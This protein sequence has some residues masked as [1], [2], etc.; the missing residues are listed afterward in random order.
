MFPFFSNTARNLPRNE[1]LIVGILVEMGAIS[2]GV[3]LKTSKPVAMSGLA[4]SLFDKALSRPIFLGIVSRR[5]GDRNFEY[6]LLA[7][8]M[9]RTRER[10]FSDRTSLTAKTGVRGY[11]RVPYQ[12]TL[13]GEE[14]PLVILDADLGSLRRLQKQREDRAKDRP[15]RNGEA[16]QL[17]KLTELMVPLRREKVWYHLEGGLQAPSGLPWR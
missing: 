1:I 10:M 5:A 13:F 15:R 4:E 12:I 2:R 3:V 14:K 6:K 16:E 8:G 9:K 17:R 7:A 11:G